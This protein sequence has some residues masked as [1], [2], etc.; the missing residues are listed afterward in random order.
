MI[1]AFAAQNPKERLTAF[2]YNKKELTDHEV[3]IKITHCGI[4]HSDIHLIDND[5]MISKYP[6]VPGHEVVGIILAA[7]SKVRH[8][9]IGDRVGVGWQ[10]GSC[11]TCEQCLSGNENLC[12]NSVATCVGRFGGFADKLIT[13][14]RFV[15]NIPANLDSENAAP[16]LCGGI[17]VYSPMR[18]YKIQPSHKIGIIGIGGLGH[19][20]IQ[21]AK[22]I[23]CQVTAFST[24]PDKE[25]EA[26][27]FGA[28]IF[29]NS[30]DEKLLKENYATL[31]FILST[32]TGALNWTSFI[33]ILKPNGRL[34]FVGATI[35]SVDINPGLLVTGQKSISGSAIGGRSMINEMLQ[36]ASRHNI[37][38]K[39]ETL[40][41]EECNEALT[42]VRN[43]KARY[44]MV[45]NNLLEK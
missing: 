27:S 33:N 18:I 13:D 32:V 24:S 20:A 43:N 30:K 12:R 21:F 45:L 22:A 16:L 1:N 2:S 35:G 4:C 39:T 5:W 40:K 28:D 41:M 37:K 42:K 14:S 9:K 26:K 44:R 38:A 19:L 10:S 11:L 31:D 23:G 8:L 7:G 6:L 36:F 15:F 34:N 17:T 3:E 29:V 25:S